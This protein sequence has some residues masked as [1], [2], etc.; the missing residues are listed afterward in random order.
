M[1]TLATSS[2]PILATMIFV[3]VLFKELFSLVKLIWKI[4]SRVLA[5]LELT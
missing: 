3:F 2:E 4:I 5:Q 1:V